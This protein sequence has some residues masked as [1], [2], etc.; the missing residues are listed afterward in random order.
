MIL[1]IFVSIAAQLVLHKIKRSSFI[2]L[3][4]EEMSII[5]NF[6]NEN[7]IIIFTHPIETMLLKVFMLLN[8]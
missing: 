6:V 2:L 3:H 1:L 4:H 7:E 8:I 5:I